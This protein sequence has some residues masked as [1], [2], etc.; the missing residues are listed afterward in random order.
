[1]IYLPELPFDLDSFIAKVEEM[2]KTK[3]SL[4]IAVSEG[5]KLADGRYV[6]ELSAADQTEDVFGHKQLAGTAQFLAGECARRLGIKARSIELSTLQRCAAHICSLT[7]INEAY[8]VGVAAVR[9]AVNG[10]TGVTVTL[11][12][13][14]SKPYEFTTSVV[15]IDKMANYEKQVPLEWIDIDNA[16]MLAPFIEYARPLIQG[17][18]T[19]VYVDG[20]PKHLVLKK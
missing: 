1:M 15:D 18:L 5:I 13:V 2:Q 19:P 10:Q 12:R 8:E 3:K 7:D 9:A 14:S 6:C 11:V 17:E 20:L 16:G 4:V